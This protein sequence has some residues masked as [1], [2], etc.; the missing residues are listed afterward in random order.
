MTIPLVSRVDPSIFWAPTFFF[1]VTTVSRED[2]AI[3]LEYIRHNLPI[4]EHESTVYKSL[5]GG[6]G[7][8]DG[9]ER[10]VIFM[11]DKHNLGGTVRYASVNN[12]LGI[13]TLKPFAEDL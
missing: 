5:A 4:L 11:H 8:C 2:I 1:R 13:G 10:S 3:K 6:V 7:I 12:H 9:T